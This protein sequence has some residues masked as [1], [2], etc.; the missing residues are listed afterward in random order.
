MGEISKDVYEKWRLEYG[1][2]ISELKAKMEKEYIL[3][4]TTGG[5]LD[6]NLDMLTDI[7]KIYEKATLLQKR[8]LI[9]LLFDDN[10]CYR[11]GEYHIVNDKLQN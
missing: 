3:L 8:E 9:R 5:I 11:K 2:Q 7:N 4:E 1:S 10:L 6:R